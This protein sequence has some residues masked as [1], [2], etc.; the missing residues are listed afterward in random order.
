MP[1]SAPQQPLKVGLPR[2]LAAAAY[3]ALIVFAL[4]FIATFVIVQIFGEPL[5]PAGKAAVQ[6]STLVIAY[7]YFAGFWSRA[8]GQTIG[9]RAWR[10]RVVDE[11]NGAVGWACASRRFLSAILSWAILGLG[12]LWSLGNPRGDA[13]HDL[14]SG[15]HLIRC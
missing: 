9:M 12:Y 1:E 6:I 7:G 2:R 10:I 3:D 13:W 15:S 11:H 4:V 8:A 14:L 5:P